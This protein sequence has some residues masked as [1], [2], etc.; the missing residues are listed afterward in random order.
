MAAIFAAH[1]CDTREAEHGDVHAFV[2]TQVDGRGKPGTREPAIVI[3]LLLQYIS[4]SAVDYPL[5][6]V[7]YVSRDG[8]Q[9]HFRS[10]TPIRLQIQ[11]DPKWPN[12]CNLPL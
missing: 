5:Y 11:A 2:A 10:G 4:N 7:R 3:W 12:I 1:H 6:T 8:V 9:I